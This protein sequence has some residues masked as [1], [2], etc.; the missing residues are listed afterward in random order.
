MQV[1]KSS[2]GDFHTK[3]PLKYRV[4][5]INYSAA[6]QRAL[7][8][9][10]LEKIDKKSCHLQVQNTQMSPPLPKPFSLIPKEQALPYTPTDC[11]LIF[12]TGSTQLKSSVLPQR[13][14]KH[15]VPILQRYEMMKLIN[16]HGYQ[17][18]E[19]QHSTSEILCFVL[20]CTTMM[21]QG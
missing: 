1:M 11:I 15:L 18:Q 14:A 13:L 8:V 5:A 2:E 6:F 20:N 12:T 4:P 17:Q 16:Y 10:P 21:H 3:N 7:R 9:S 19:D